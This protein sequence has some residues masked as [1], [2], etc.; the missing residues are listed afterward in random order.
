MNKT[1]E[2]KPSKTAFVMALRRALANKEC[3][4]GKFGPDY[5]AEYFL[6]IR[7]RFFLR[8]EKIRIDTKHKMDS[9][10]PGLNLYAIAR[11]SYFDRLFANALTDKIPQIVL[12]GAGYDS[13]A[14]RFAHL[15]S[16]T[17]IFELDVA[18]TQNRKKKCLKRAQIDIPP[19][20]HFVPI[21]F[22]EQS[23]GDCLEKAGYKHGEKT[24]FIW[25]GVTFYL[26]PTSIDSTLEFVSSSSRDS[27]VAFDYLVSVDEQTAHNYYGVSGLLATL[28]KYS[29]NEALKFMIGDGEIESFLRQRGLRVIEHLDNQAIEMNYLTDSNGCMI[30]R[31]TEGFRF[32]SA[33]PRELPL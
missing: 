9:S 5:L 27:M 30:G 24:L 25:E 11:T 3:K 19:Q 23:L 6:S 4:D 13:R 26:D 28:K 20:I 29:K 8:F 22:N 14:Y 12:L 2:H 18:P 10:T 1:V 32:V 31:V 7:V 17:R 15:N 33:S 21:N 16:G